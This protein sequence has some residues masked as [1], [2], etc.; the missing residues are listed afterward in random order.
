MYVLAD[1]GT[2]TDRDPG[3]DHRAAIDISADVD[4]RRHQDCARGNVR[5][6]TGDSIRHHAHAGFGEIF[7]RITSIFALDF[8]V[9]T[10]VAAVHHAVF[11]D[12]EGQQHGFFQP[13]VGDPIAVDYSPRRGLCQY[14]ARPRASL[15]AL[16]TS[17]LAL[18]GVMSARFSKAVLMVFSSSVM[19]IA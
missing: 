4:V 6:F 1:L 14:R 5:A 12:A 11:V 15:T 9:I 10:G 13:L 8:V 19:V 18:A 7:F 2:G 3:I 16:R 17:A